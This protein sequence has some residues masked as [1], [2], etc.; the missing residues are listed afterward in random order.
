MKYGK[1]PCRC[2]H[3]S[4]KNWWLTGVGGFVQGSGFTEDEADR[5]VDLLNAV[6][7]DIVDVIRISGDGDKTYWHPHQFPLSKRLRDCA[8]DTF[9]I[10]RNGEFDVGNLYLITGALAGLSITA[11]YQIEQMEHGNR[12]EV[13]EKD[14]NNRGVL[15]ADEVDGDQA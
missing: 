14:H 7:P 9:Q 15:W 8:S 2:G 4:C 11:S 12:Q 10:A 13:P 3:P 1:E 5:I 6:D